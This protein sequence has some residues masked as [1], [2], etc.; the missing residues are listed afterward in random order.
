MK[1]W[2]KRITGLEKIETAILIAERERIAKEEEVNRLH[3]EQVAAVAK[4]ELAVKQAKKQQELA[5][6][7][8]K[9]RATKDNEP[10]VDIVKVELDADN[11]SYGS[12]ELDWNEHFVKKLRD[13]GYPG[14]SDEVVVDLWF[15]SVCR[16]IL[17]E[18][19]EQD[20]AN[21]GDN[22]RYI[23]RRDLGDGKTEVS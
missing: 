5:K 21:R 22:I 15:Q 6:L 10:Y 12:F 18:T 20:A 4:A 2:L 11:P 19:Y 16:N 14:D 8:P 9:K 3:K 7:S 1:K 13:L 17:M 23:N